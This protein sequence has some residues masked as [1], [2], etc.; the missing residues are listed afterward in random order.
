MSGVY[1]T[2]D[3]TQHHMMWRGINGNIISGMPT[4][5]LTRTRCTWSGKTSMFVNFTTE[6]VWFR[7]YC[8]RQESAPYLCSFLQSKQTG[9]KSS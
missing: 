2:S 9:V 4:K 7:P 8:G 1:L 5:S 6:R 3:C